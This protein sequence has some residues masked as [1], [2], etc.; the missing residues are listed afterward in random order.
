MDVDENVSTVSHVYSHS[1]DDDD[2]G[3]RSD[4]CPHP[5]L[6]W[7][8]DVFLVNAG[9]WQTMQLNSEIEEHLNSKHGT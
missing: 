4:M 8:V 2:V 1:H 5:H 9:E 7:L 6:R 3:R